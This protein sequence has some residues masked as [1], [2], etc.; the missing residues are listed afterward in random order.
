MAVLQYD[1]ALLIDNINH[2]L[3]LETLMQRH[4]YDHERY[5]LQIYEVFD[6]NRVKSHQFINDIQ[7]IIRERQD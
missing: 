1:L 2:Q 5:I 7:V 4:V 6:Q 3:F